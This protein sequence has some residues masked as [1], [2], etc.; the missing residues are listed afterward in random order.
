MRKPVV[1]LDFK[2]TS[3]PLPTPVMLRGP[4]QQQLFADLCVWMV[5]LGAESRVG[6]HAMFQDRG[7]LLNIYCRGL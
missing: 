4:F 6:L 5:N 7:I 3:Y 1:M 2:H